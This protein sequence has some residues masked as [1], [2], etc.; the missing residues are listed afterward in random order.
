LEV[1]ILSSA[2]IA[3]MAQYGRRGGLKNR[4]LWVRIPLPA[5]N[6]VG[7]AQMGER[8]RAMLEAGSSNLLAHFKLV[9]WFSARLAEWIQARGRNPRQVGSIPA[10]CFEYLP[11]WRNGPHARSLNLRTFWG[12][13]SLLRHGGIYGGLARAKWGLIIPASQERYLGPQL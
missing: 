13:D 5:L 9:I 3:G 7:V 4:K 2:L 1:R 6:F 8:E 11:K 12:F 10:P